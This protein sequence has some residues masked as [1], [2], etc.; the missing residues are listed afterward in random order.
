MSGNKYIIAFVDWY[1]G[2][3]EAFAVPDKMADTVADL[4]I[5]QIFPR[6][7]SLQIVSDNGTKN[8]N[9][10]VKETLAKLKIDHVL[11]SVYHPQSNAKVERFHRTLHDVLAKKVADNQ[12]TWD[13]FLNQAL[14]AIRFN[15]SESSKFSPFFLMY[16]RDVVLPIDNILQP[17]KKY[18]GEEY[19][20]SA[21]QDHC[22][23]VV[24]RPR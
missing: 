1:S 14:A 24:L 3:P 16:N 18:V 10:S 21:L 4:I 23:I 17:R 15:V 11:T 7:G 8:V 6:F 13:L 5:E 2:R 20:Q 12:Q 19:H 9:K 22:Y